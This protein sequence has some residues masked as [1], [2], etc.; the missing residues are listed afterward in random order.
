MN[1]TRTMSSHNRPHYCYTSGPY[2]TGVDCLSVY[3]RKFNVV[4]VYLGY[5][6]VPLTMSLKMRSPGLQSRRG[7]LMANQD[8]RTHKVQVGFPNPTKLSTSFFT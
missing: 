5:S 6:R 3:M 2:E 4:E 1:S 7:E 8:D